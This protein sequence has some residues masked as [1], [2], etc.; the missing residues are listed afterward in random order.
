MKNVRHE[1]NSIFIKRGENVLR[2]NKWAWNELEE[3]SIWDTI[4]GLYA[5]TIVRPFG[6]LNRAGEHF[7]ERG[8]KLSIKLKEIISRAQGNFE[9]QNKV[10]KP[11]KL[12]LIIALLFI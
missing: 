3:K 7:W 4:L 11:F 8:P 1:K 2:W 6:S 9:G 12:L 5:A 10:L